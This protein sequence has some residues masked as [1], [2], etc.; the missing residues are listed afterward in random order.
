MKPAVILALALSAAISA[1]DVKDVNRTVA[2]NGNGLVEIETHKGSIRVSTWDRAEV[3]IQARIE[4]ETG[5]IMDRRRFD[6]TEVRIDSSPDSVHIRTYY[7]DFAWCCSGD[8]NGSNPEVRYTVRMP[9]TA[10]LAI[11]DHRS[12]TEVTGLQGA[13]DLFTHRGS[14]RVHG[15]G[16]ALRV[17]THRGDIQVDF[18]SFTANSSVTTY[19]GTI[20]LSMP[21]SSRFDLEADLGRRGGIDTDFTMMSRTIGR[22]GESMHGTVNGGGPALSIKAERGEVR[23][24]AR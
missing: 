8:D 12:D 7:P 13:L 2:L 15:L 1:A 6:G 11:R 22:R 14:A 24:H 3:E 9:M 20:D 4:A 23:I 18:S 21:K 16:G 19:R 10:R 17:D 5:S